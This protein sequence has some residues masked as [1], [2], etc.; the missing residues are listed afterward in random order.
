MSF[1]LKVSQEVDARRKV[2]HDEFRYKGLFHW[3]HF[4][5]DS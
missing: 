3:L 2:G 4:E 5:S 1:P